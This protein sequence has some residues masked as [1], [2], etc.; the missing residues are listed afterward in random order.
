MKGFVRYLLAPALAV[1]LVAAP[2]GA[3]ITTIVNDLSPEESGAIL[4]V[5]NVKGQKIQ[6]NLRIVLNPGETKK[7]SVRNIYRFTVSRIYG[8]SRDKFIVSCPTDPRVRNKITLRLVDITHNSMPAG[9]RLERTGKWTRNGG[10]TWD[11]ELATSQ[12]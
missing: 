6:P 11:E 1:T 3:V 5:S 12:R 8:D 9:C 10:T 2:A 7:I 4:E